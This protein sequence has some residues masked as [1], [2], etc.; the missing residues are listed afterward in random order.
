[1]SKVDEATIALSRITLQPAD[2]F[3]EFGDTVAAPLGSE[4]FPSHARSNCGDTA[5]LSPDLK[6]GPCR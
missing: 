1:M 5:V 6:L 2:I 4:Y 3:F